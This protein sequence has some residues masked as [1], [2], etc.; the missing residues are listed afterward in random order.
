MQNLSGNADLSF[1]DS[2]IRE[3][4]N[5]AEVTVPGQVLDGSNPLVPGLG[6]SLPLLVST[7][8]SAD[9]GGKTLQQGDYLFT[10]EV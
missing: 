7:F 6:R 8:S 2:S 9:G 10:E 3:R 1:K 4:K 5:E